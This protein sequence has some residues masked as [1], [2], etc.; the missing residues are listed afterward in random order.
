[1]RRP[2]TGSNSMNAKNQV[3][4]IAYLISIWPYRPTFLDFPALPEFNP[5]VHRK[6]V[7]FDPPPGPG[8]RRPTPDS[9]MRPRAQKCLERHTREGGYPVRRSFSVQSELLWDTGSPAFA[10][11]DDSSRSSKQFCARGRIALSGVGLRS[12]GS[13][14][15]S[16][17]TSFRE[18]AGL[19][20]RKA[21]KSRKVATDYHYT[22]IKAL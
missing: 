10:G 6:D 4:T 8:G 15:G 19:N 13:G 3:I 14:G 21:A 9:A 12:Q 22:S 16:K 7:L 5:R 18:V 11:D 20:P 2:E 17:R 1:M